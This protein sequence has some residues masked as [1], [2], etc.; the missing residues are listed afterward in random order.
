MKTSCW[1]QSSDPV[2]S[3]NGS[4]KLY[5]S[6]VP[7]ISGSFILAWERHLLSKLRTLFFKFSSKKVEYSA[8]CVQ[9][10]CKQFQGRS[11][12]RLRHPP[13]LGM[14][15]AFLEPPFE[16][17]RAGFGSSALCPALAAIVLRISSKVLFYP[18]LQLFLGNWAP[19][20][21]L[22]AP[23]LPLESNPVL[24]DLATS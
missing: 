21:H 6:F 17:L 9:K 14:A 23:S 7:S 15:P 22:Q 4:R 11:A 18:G 19:T 1:T 3:Q 24:C 2:Q 16:S 13:E 8:R 20:L 5:E 10:S 12:G